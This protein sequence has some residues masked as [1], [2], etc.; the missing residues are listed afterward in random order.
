MDWMFYV[1][2]MFHVLVIF[3]HI[4]ALKVL[5]NKK[6][7]RLKGNQKMLL[8]TLS[9]A[10]LTYA[11]V[12]IGKLLCFLHNLINLN[13][14]FFTLNFV[15][16]FWMYWVIMTLITV[17][18]FL[19]IYL[20]IKYN[21]LC[22]P[23]KT[24]TVLIIAIVISFLLLVPAFQVKKETLISFGILF[25]YPILESFFIILA[26]V[27]YLY[28]FKQV[29]RHRKITMKVQKQLR[30]N[31]RVTNPMHFG[32]RFKVFVPSLIIITFVFFMFVPN[33]I[34]LSI[35]KGFVKPEVQGIVFIL[36]PIGLVA[37]PVIY[38]FSLKGIRQPS[39]KTVWSA[40]SICFSS[41]ASRA[42]RADSSKIWA[43]TV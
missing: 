30:R 29:L 6:Q 19:E 34:S 16:T 10:E 18:R 4:V 37:D 21:I 23:K 35:L 9:V 2:L 20:N 11:V 31:N 28:I 3:T 33:A 13:D 8:I 15:S 12:N 32:N 39:I 36:I 40:N 26:S 24:K 1:I 41:H 7:K 14:A 17:D 22:S 38:I 43:H 25:C 5:I 42:S 27:T